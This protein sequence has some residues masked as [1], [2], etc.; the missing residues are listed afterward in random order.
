M[1]CMHNNRLP[2]LFLVAASA[3]MTA[4]CTT[5]HA[6]EQEVNYNCS[7]SLAL[8][9]TFSEGKAVVTEEGFPPSTL[10]Q[11]ETGSGFLYSDG[12][13][14]LEGKGDLT[15]WTVGRRAS[16]NCTVTEQ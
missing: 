8:K 16:A 12:S 3:L 7:D 5:A 4:S 10:P 6:S 15:I 9:V 14:T 1:K 13:R 2:R 11:K